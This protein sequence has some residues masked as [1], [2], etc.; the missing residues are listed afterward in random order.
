[1]S[2]TL[3]I[4]PIILLSGVA[5]CTSCSFED[6][7]R[8]E[9]R[10]FPGEDAG[11]ADFSP[12]AFLKEQSL[13]QSE[14]ADAWE[15]LPYERIGLTRTACFTGCPEYSLGFIRGSGD[16]TRAHAVYDARRNVASIGAFEGSITLHAYAQLCQLVDQL[17][18]ITLEPEYRASWP[19]DSS[20]IVDVRHT[21]GDYEIVDYGAQ[22]P[23]RL[24][25]VQLAIDG[26]AR[27]ID[28]EAIPEK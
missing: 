15:R 5:L 23:P 16:D 14:L 18:I 3:G 17:G 13:S 22:G 2:Q 8:V 26:S 11:G 6:T 7:T 25:G 4:G 9:T 19:G 1:M 20:A 12:Y 24:I 10:T 21:S 27:G 28:W